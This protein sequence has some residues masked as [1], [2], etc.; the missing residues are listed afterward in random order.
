MFNEQEK[1][2]A[3]HRKRGLTA[4]YHV[5]QSYKKDLKCKKVKVFSDNQGACKILVAGSRKPQL[6][7]LAVKIFKIS[8]ENSLLLKS[9]WI[10][11]DDNERAD[12]IKKILDKDD[13]RLYPSSFRL[14]DAIRGDPHL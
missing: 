10:P 11:R 8:V 6:R 14:I 2:T 13:W 1:A 9:R 12:Q 5:L 7:C 4:I 3:Q